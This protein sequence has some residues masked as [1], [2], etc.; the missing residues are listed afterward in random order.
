MG[1]FLDIANLAEPVHRAWPEIGRKFQER[2]S[3]SDLNLSSWRIASTVA[4]TLAGI[5]CISTSVEVASRECRNNATT[6]GRP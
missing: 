2:A 4:F 1:Q 5:S 6:P 3:I